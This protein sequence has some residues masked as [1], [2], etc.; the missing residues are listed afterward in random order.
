MGGAHKRFLS[1]TS[2]DLDKAIR[3]SSLLCLAINFTFFTFIIYCTRYVN[4]STSS[5]FGYDNFP[6]A[7]N[8]LSLRYLKPLRRNELPMRFSKILFPGSRRPS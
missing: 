1:M 2:C 6:R 5:A 4:P 3:E 7:G 8:N